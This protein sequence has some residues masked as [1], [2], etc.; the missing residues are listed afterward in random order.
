MHYALTMTAESPFSARQTD[1]ICDA[2]GEEFDSALISGNRLE[3]DGAG[4]IAVVS[5]LIERLSN[6]LRIAVEY[7][8]SFPR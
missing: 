1:A 2:L 3:V 7:K 5:Q 6:H 4:G 8:V